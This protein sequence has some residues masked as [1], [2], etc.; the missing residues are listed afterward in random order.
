VIPI[1]E[2]QE[3]MEDLQDLGVVAERREEAR[4]SLEDVKQR[5]RE[6]GLLPG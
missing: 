2:Y 4:T 6:D 1:D 3:L 5:L